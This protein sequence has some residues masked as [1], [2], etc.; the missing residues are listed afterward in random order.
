MIERRQCPCRGYD[1]LCSCQNGKE[2]VTEKQPADVWTMRDELA[3]R[4]LTSLIA[5]EGLLKLEDG[6]LIRWA[7]RCA[8]AFLSVTLEER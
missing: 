7:Y 2:K 3:A 5:K 6:S 8:D 1:D 4:L